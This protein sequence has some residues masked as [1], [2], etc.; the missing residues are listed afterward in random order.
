MTE[1]RQIVQAAYDE[2][3]AGMREDEAQNTARAATAAVL[4]ELATLTE[5]DHTLMAPGAIRLIAD[6]IHGETS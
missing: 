1:A 5:H 2:M 6:H 4:R 3:P